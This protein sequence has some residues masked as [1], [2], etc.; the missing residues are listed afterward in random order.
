MTPSLTRVRLY[1]IG[2]LAAIPPRHPI[3]RLARF[4]RLGRVVPGLSNKYY[5]ELSW[6][7]RWAPLFRNNV[8]KVLHYWREY[9][10]FDDITRLL[11]LTETS[12]ILD[13]GCGIST[14]LHFLPGERH[15]IDPLA[16]E[17]K[18]I[19]RY[20]DGIHVTQGF[21]EAIPFPDSYF[22][23]VFCSNVL[24]HTS[25]PPKVVE[26]MYRVMRPGGHLVLTVEIFP[27]ARERDLS[28][29][30]A[31]T[32]A[33]VRELLNGRFVSLFEKESPWIMLM[34]YV[35]G[36]MKREGDQLIVVA[37]KS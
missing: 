8:D 22:D 12:R 5:S 27:S 25:D 11:S 24:D 37:R 30:H 1:L 2:R 32:K 23:A 20:P 10:F 7:N 15:G 29:P 16:E 21:G 13:V 36:S 4:L 9:R 3:K 14:V 33:E 34:H 26:E 35:D 18:R 17:Y 19:Y 6:Q 31:F 28:H